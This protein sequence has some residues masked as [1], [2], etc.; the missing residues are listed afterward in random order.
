VLTGVEWQWREFQGMDDTTIDV[1]H[2]GQYTL[3]L[4]ADGSYSF[5]ADCNVGGGAYTRDGSSLTLEPGP[6]TLAA[7]PPDSLSD[8]FVR[9]LGYVRSFVMEDGEL[10]LAL[11]ADGGILRF[12]PPDE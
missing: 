5:R 2:P 6:I 1:D 12:A 4:R 11:F 3:E 10:F 7:C 8:R 9:D